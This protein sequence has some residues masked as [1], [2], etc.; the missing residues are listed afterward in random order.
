MV[1]QFIYFCIAA[2]YKS[3]VVLGAWGVGWRKRVAR[4]SLEE[5]QFSVLIVHELEE[6]CNG[7]K[8]VLV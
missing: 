7:S 6:F 8:Q 5:L 3:W 1:I 2:N 4:N